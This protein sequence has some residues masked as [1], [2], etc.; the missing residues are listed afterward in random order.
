[1][2]YFFGRLRWLPL[3]L[4]L[5]SCG[6]GSSTSGGSGGGGS[7]TPFTGS[8]FLVATLN[9]NIGGTATF[10]TDSSEVIVGAGGNAVVTETDS[11]CS[12][13]VFVNGDVMTYETTC[14]FTATVDDVTAPCELTA[15]ARAP[16]RGQQG[17]AR[18]SAS[19]GPETRVCSGAAASFA[20]TLV[21]R[22]GTAPDTDTNGDTD[23]ET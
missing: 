23:D 18:A 21:A 19:F 9:V 8:W 13:N 10:L 3:V 15:V 16:I 20:G 6:G 14:I 2:Q 5:A 1:M 11:E 4:L 17:N 7:A 12:L 22:Q